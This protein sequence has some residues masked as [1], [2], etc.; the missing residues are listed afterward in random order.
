MLEEKLQ[1]HTNIECKNS[2]YLAGYFTDCKKTEI[3][4]LDN[5]EED[6]TLTDRAI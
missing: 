6:A 1:E 4:K 2:H 3:K 5:S